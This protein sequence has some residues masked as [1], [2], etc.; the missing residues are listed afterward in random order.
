MFLLSFSIVL[1]LLIMDIF[2]INE[3]T[4]ENMSLKDERFYEFLH[5]AVGPDLRELFQVQAI[6]N[7]PSLLTTSFDVLIEIFNFDI[8][9]LTF[10]KAKLGFVSADGRYHLR[11]G[12]KN[13]LERL[14]LLVKS[15]KAVA[16][17]DLDLL[18][19]TMTDDILQRLIGVWKRR[20]DSSKESD[21]P[22][23]LPLI[24]NIFHNSFKMKNRYSYE[25]SVQQFALSVL[26][27]GGRNCYEFL[28]L[29]L[30]GALPHPSN[31]ESLIREN[32]RRIIECEFRFQLLGDYL[33]A[34]KCR[35]AFSCEDCTSVV[36]RIDY[37][38]QSNSF[39]GFSPPLSNGIP[40]KDFFQT[41]SFD[42]FASWM[43]KFDRSKLINLHVVQPLTLSVSPFIL[44]A[45]GTNGKV[46]ATDVLQRWLYIYEKCL[47][48]GVR[49]VGFS[50]DGDARYLRAMRL[51]TRF[52]AELPNMSTIA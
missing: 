22:I 24:K 31:L 42:E 36:C 13:L 3:L 46:T 5:S 4:D 50:T 1:S 39:I 33:R 6:K 26:I 18:D 30:P 17:R 12:C 15:K 16:K 9:E 48:Y 49:I 7:M 28:R 10:L 47:S 51:C 20:S 32:G 38:V 37:D 34:S 19:T 45:Y 43:E 21:P 52:F 25:N 29:N 2:Q 41:D 23:L 8:V 27:L 44:S 35:Y 14:L 40:Q 11:L